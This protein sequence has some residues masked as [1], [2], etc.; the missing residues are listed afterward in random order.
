MDHGGKLASCTVHAHVE[1]PPVIQSIAFTERKPR[2][3]PCFPQ[4]VRDLEMIAFLEYR[5]LGDVSCARE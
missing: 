3:K 1:M 2:G 5:I 4:K